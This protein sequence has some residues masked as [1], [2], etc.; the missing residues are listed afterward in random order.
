MSEESNMPAAT[1]KKVVKKGPS[2]IDL[3]K[4]LFKPKPKILPKIGGHLGVTT[5]QLGWDKKTFDL[6]YKLLRNFA[7]KSPENEKEVSL[8]LF[9]EIEKSAQIEPLYLSFFWEEIWEN[10]KNLDLKIA[11]ICLGL[12]YQFIATNLDY[13]K[14]NPDL[15]WKELENSDPQDRVIGETIANEILKE[16]P[17]W[18]I[19]HF[20][21]FN[22]NLKSAFKFLQITPLTTNDNLDSRQKRI[23]HKH[24][25]PPRKKKEKLNAI[26][27]DS[28]VN[29]TSSTDIVKPKG[30]NFNYFIWTELIDRFPKLIV[31]NWSD[32]VF[33]IPYFKTSLLDQNGKKV[34]S[35]LRYAAELMMNEIDL[36]IESEGKNDEDSDEKNIFPR[37]LVDALIDG[38]IAQII[39]GSIISKP[40]VLDHFLELILLNIHNR[41]DL[42]KNR[43]RITG[44]VNQDQCLLLTNMV[45]REYMD[46]ILVEDQ[47]FLVDLYSTTFF[48]HIG[49]AED[50]NLK[51]FL[52]V[53]YH[54]HNNHNF[55]SESTHFKYLIL[56]LDEE[57]PNIKEHM[58]YLV[59]SVIKGNPTLLPVLLPKIKFCLQT[60]LLDLLPLGL[61]LLRLINELI[62]FYKDTEWI[63]Y[64][65]NQVG[66]FY[67]SNFQIFEI[68]YLIANFFVFISEFRI[69][70][71]NPYRNWIE[72]QIIEFQNNFELKSIY[73]KIRMK[74]IRSELKDLKFLIKN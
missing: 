33:W 16:D 59:F 70:L 28:E 22:K 2:I 18:F 21:R 26:S 74:I 73:S 10:K 37:S 14:R 44:W 5:E 64:I 25:R 57:N 71:L 58:K 4:N 19:P 67:L 45:L 34:P 52:K 32:M 51:K 50:S 11:K 24:K 7:T 66:E 38:L 31:D 47:I 61:F 49:Y 1:P 60:D 43:N 55:F 17:D 35:M 13:F 20:A 68:Q 6:W 3:I 48:P 46:K 29:N 40:H 39:D 63:D 23:K 12:T 69:D 42:F 53:L 56:G 72:S 15:I 62:L 54:L 27:Q 8:L 65:F 30:I 9:Q 41:P 36:L